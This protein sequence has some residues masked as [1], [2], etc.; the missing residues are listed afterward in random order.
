MK[1]ARTPD[2]PC[3]NTATIEAISTARW[4]SATPD[5]SR[6]FAPDDES[7]CRLRRALIGVADLNA[8]WAIQPSD[9]GHAFG[10]NRVSCEVPLPSTDSG[11]T[12]VLVREATDGTASALVQQALALESGVAADFMAGLRHSCSTLATDVEN[13]G[14]YEPIDLPSFADDSV[15]YRDLGFPRDEDRKARDDDGTLYIRRG[16]ILVFVS[17]FQGGDLNLADAAAL[18]SEKVDHV[19][20]LPEPTPVIGEGCTPPPTSTPEDD[21]LAAAV[22][23]LGDMPAGWIPYRPQPCGMLPA[24]GTCLDDEDLPLPVA[25]AQGSF[26][27]TRGYL[28]QHV[29]RYDGDD[30]RRVMDEFARRLESSS[31]CTA[32]FETGDVRRTW[33]SVTAP[34]LGQ[35]AAAWEVT[36]T[37]GGAASVST[38]YAIRRGST[39]AFITFAPRSEPGRLRSH[40]LDTLLAPFARQADA[41]LREVEPDP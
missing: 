17:L 23:E 41:K 33:T 40:L 19:G 16:D 18:V 9:S 15:G 14:L 3:T 8:D 26:E 6:L 27:S 1:S 38:T 13:E 34:A 22:V 29:E 31:T 32:K 7:Q 11:V 36:H 20:E 5:R 30:A 39:I 25:I 35:Q 37:G 4:S 10:G 21:Q 12:V 2:A 24:G 28:F